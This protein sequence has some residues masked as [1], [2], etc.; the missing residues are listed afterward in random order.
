MQDIAVHGQVLACTLA[1]WID[2]WIRVRRKCGRVSLLSSISVGLWPHLKLSA[3][4]FFVTRIVHAVVELTGLTQLEGLR[5]T[6]AVAPAVGLIVL[7]ER[8]IRVT[9]EGFYS[10]WL[11]YYGAFPGVRESFLRE[12]VEPLSRME[13]DLAARVRAQFEV[14]VNFLFERLK[15][16]RRRPHRYLARDVMIRNPGKKAEILCR[17]YGIHKFQQMLNHERSARDR[18]RMRWNWDFSDRRGKDVPP[19]VGEDPRPQWRG[20]L[21]SRRVESMGPA[22]AAPSERRDLAS[23]YGRRTTDE[24]LARG[25][26]LFRRLRRWDPDRRRRDPAVR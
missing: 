20:A 6:L 22:T 7:T 3:F 18:E 12:A 19:A 9:V 4:Y 8:L 13:C 2:T 5:A 11:P 15:A 17:T 23:R 26:W 10:E 24:R 16:Q 21:G 14:E 1:G 25:P